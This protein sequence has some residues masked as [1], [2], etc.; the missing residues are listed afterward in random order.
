MATFAGVTL[1]FPGTFLDR[2]WALNPVGHAGLTA[3]GRWVGFLFPLL[4]LT[5]AAAGMGWLKR[6]RWGWVLA[7][8]LIG[9]NAAGDLVRLASG[10]WAAGTVGVL[11][12]GALLVYM[13]RPG[14]RRVFPPRD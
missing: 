3:R 6:R 13:T 5:L 11:M 9:G 12:A 8:L 7:I 14:M 1:I 2:A 4:G 10:A